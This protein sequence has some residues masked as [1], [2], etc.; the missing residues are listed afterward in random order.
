MN[1]QKLSQYR[2]LLKEL[3]FLKSKQEIDHVVGSNDEFP[4][5]ERKFSIKGVPSRYHRKLKQCERLRKEIE[6]YID[7]IP[8]SQIR[9]ILELRYL[10]GKSWKDIDYA[11]GNYTGTYSIKIHDNYLRK[12]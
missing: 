10:E 2:S 12:T 4:Y 7:S 8:D 1:R 5:E 9:L 3:K 11:F 6:D